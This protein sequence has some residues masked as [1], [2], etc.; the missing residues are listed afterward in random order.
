MA[1]HNQFSKE[2]GKKV[3]KL[4]HM[5]VTKITVFIHGLILYDMMELFFG[6]ENLCH[7]VLTTL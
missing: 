5:D 7:D 1:S 2:G 6:H 4:V 3:G